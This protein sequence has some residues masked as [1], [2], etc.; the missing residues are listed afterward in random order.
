M[1]DKHHHHPVYLFTIDSLRAD[2]FDSD[3]FPSCWDRF[4]SDFARFTNAY[5]NGIA[6]PLAFPSIL[7]DDLVSGNGVLDEDVTTL[8]ERFPER[9]IAVRNN[10]HISR[11]RGYHRGFAQ[12]DLDMSARD[13]VDRAIALRCFR[14][15]S[16]KHLRRK[17]PA[18]RD[19]VVPLPYRPAERMEY[20]IKQVMRATSP[21]FLWSHFMD[22]HG[23][24]HPD[25]VFDREIPVSFD[26]EEF[27]HA[28]R[29]WDD[30][31]KLDSETVEKMVRIYREKIRYLDRHL[32]ALFEWLEATGRYRDALIIVTADHGQLLGENGRYGHDWDNLPVDELLRVPFLVKYPDGSHASDVFSHPVQHLDIHATMADHAPTDIGINP[33]SNRLTD[34]SD[35]FIIAK[36]NAAIRGL[37]ADGE[38]LR[39]LDGELTMSGD[40]DSA[41]ADKVRSAQPAHVTNDV[42]QGAMTKEER[43]RVNKQ[44]EDL[45]YL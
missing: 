43:E 4:A 1:S 13:Y 33:D 12:F 34:P 39:E 32:Q 31:D 36:S 19:P 10:V 8:A 21:A 23:P 35:R 11:E 28:Q 9:A 6:T 15:N 22:P 42:G 25:L 24:Y 7:A 44:L 17:A 40:V 41:L 26:P 5:A 30:D 37:S 3:H 16:A 27:K 45:G 29:Q 2:F 14:Q 20:E 18:V 38:V